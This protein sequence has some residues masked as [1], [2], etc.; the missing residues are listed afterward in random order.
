MT[1]A[2]G[3]SFVN[4]H[5]AVRIG[6]VGPAFAGTEARIADDGEILLR[7]PG[8][9]RGYHNLPEATAEVLDAEGWLAT[10][11]VGEVDAD[12]FLKI[13]DRKKDLVKTSGGKYIAPS[14]VE[15]S[16]KVASPLIGQAVVI[17]D[18][19]KFPSALITLDPDAVARFAEINSIDPADVPG[20]ARVK[21]QVKAAVDT[22]NETLN[23]WEKI[24]QFRILPR[25]LDVESGELTPSLKIK[26]AVV[27]RHY[28]DVIDDMYGG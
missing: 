1:E 5:G 11:D 13:T 9:M 19:R 28:A 4:R 2:S 22:V 18:G 17:A 8:V 16:L 14:A 7:S 15:G 25:E 20:D 21:A 23:R 6:S 3:G 27:A 12:G 24:K 26:R 10:G